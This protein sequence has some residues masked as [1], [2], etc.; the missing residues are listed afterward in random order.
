[1]IITIDG[2]EYE[3]RPTMAALFAYQEATGKDD[4]NLTMATPK[5]MTWFVW[6]ALQHYPEPPTFDQVAGVV[7]ISDY[8][9]IAEMVVGAVS[10]KNQEG[11]AGSQSGRSPA[12]GSG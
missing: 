7:M 12:S 5:E 11:D 1:M 8:P 9:K 2:K 4:D 10:P 3:C 6:A